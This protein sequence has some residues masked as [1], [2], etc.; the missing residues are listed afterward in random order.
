MTSHERLHALDAVRAGAL[1][2]GVVF[3]AGFS[4]IPGMPP[5]IWAMVDSSPSTPLAVVLFASH[6]FRMTLF[7]VIA[8]VFARMAFHRRGARRFWADRA[9]RIL[10]PLDRRLAGAGAD[11]DGRVDLGPDADVRRRAAGTAGQP[12]APAGGCLPVHAP[13]VPVLP[14]DPVRARDRGPRHRGGRRHAGRA[15]SG[16]PTRWSP[17]SCGRARQR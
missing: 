12:P 5:G 8:G 14:A 2:L 15:A 13:V 1:L 3:H 6:M 9:S 16:W 17:A 7:F 4:F 11:D 10:V